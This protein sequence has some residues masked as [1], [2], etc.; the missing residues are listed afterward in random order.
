MEG[1]F[2]VSDMYRAATRTACT[3]STVNL[4]G[5]LP[6]NQIAEYVYI[7]TNNNNY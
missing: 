5:R 3:M 2:K 7:N 6:S 4:S 1:V